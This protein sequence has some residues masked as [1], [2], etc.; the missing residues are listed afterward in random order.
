MAKRGRTEDTQVTEVTEADVTKK[1]KLTDTDAVTTASGP[2]GRRIAQLMKQTK[3][4]YYLFFSDRVKE[5]AEKPAGIPKEALPAKVREEW[6][7]HKNSN[8]ETF[9]RYKAAETAAPASP[10]AKHELARLQHIA[11]N[12]RQNPQMMNKYII[13]KLCVFLGQATTDQRAQRAYDRV[14]DFTAIAIFPSLTH[15]R[16]YKTFEGILLWGV[17]NTSVGEVREKVA[18]KL[19]RTKQCW[20]TN[21]LCWPCGSG[22][23]I[24]PKYI[25]ENMLQE[26]VNTFLKSLDDDDES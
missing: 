15:A 7:E 21:L 26:V 5:E 8:T 6:Q 12:W 3:S 10:L 16:S 19:H 11:V 4:A 24:H 2:L 13:D 20:A 1:A 9:K 14:C 23:R 22:T 25:L 18:K 17:A